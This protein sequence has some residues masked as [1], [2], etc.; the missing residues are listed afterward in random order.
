MGIAH[1]D[2]PWSTIDADFGVGPVTIY[3]RPMNIR[4]RKLIMAAR[5]KSATDFAVESLIL[6]SRTEA[7]QRIWRTNADRE[8]IERTYDPDELDRVIG[9]MYAVEESAGN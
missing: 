9:I 8:T 7:G 2:Q 4:E 5:E 6:R 1:T 3:Y